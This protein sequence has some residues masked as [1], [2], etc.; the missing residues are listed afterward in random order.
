V[1]DETAIVGIGA[2][3]YFRRGASVPE[4]TLSM[5]VT[6]IRDAIEDAGLE[7]RDLDGFSIYSNAVDPGEVAAVLGIPELRW[8]TTLTQGGGGSAG[9][10]GVAAAAVHAGMAEVVVTVMSLQ[11]AGRRLGGSAGGGLPAMGRAAANGY[12]AGGVPASFA[13]SASAGVASPG[14][15]FALIA[16]RHMHL[17]GTTRHH[18]AEVV[19]THRE[20]ASNRPTALQRTPLTVDDYFAARM[21]SDPMCLLDHSL[22]SDGA[23]AAIVT[24]ASRAR[25]LRH[26]PVYVM[27]SAHGGAGRW[28]KAIVNDFQA[29]DEYFASSGHRTVATRA[30]EMAGVGPADVDVALLYDHFSPMVLLQLEDYGFCPIGESGPFVAD[31]NIRMTGSIPVNPHGGNLSEAYIIGMTHVREAVEQL[32][33]TAVNQVVGAEVALVTGGPAAAPVSATVLRR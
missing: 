11:Q 26:R 15:G 6:A 1:R 7:V 31:G 18:F 21:I 32:R 29:P 28:G 9:A 13:F 20:N 17:Y 10:V 16:Q 12:G 3:P 22:E 30:F 25:H 27:G 24:S 8:S 4:T 33:G 5:A 23:V 2:T 14:H 19:L